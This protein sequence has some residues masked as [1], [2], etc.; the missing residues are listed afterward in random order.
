[1]I[2]RVEW[3]WI[4]LI[5]I[6]YGVL[7]TRYATRTPDWQAPDEPAHVNYVRQIADEG[8][9]SRRCTWAIGTSRIRTR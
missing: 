4:G 7:V 5:L 6:G 9:S 8:I 3:I 2:R 1:M